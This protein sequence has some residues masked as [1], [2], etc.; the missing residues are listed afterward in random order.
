MMTLQSKHVA[1]L[2]FLYYYIC[3][4]RRIQLAVCV[5]LRAVC[6]YVYVVCERPWV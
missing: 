1:F 2:A 4:V 5:R 3:C 6:Y